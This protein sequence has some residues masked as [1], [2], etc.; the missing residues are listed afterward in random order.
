METIMKKTGTS[1]G[2]K[3]FK[4]RRT[5]EV[6]FDH[7]PDEL[8]SKIF[9]NLSTSDLLTKVARVSKRFHRLSQDSD[10]HVAVQIPELYEVTQAASLLDFMKGKT[11]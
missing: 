8:V 2:R 11:T 10:A 6:G 4:N 9:S 1:E 7:L 3:V 5:E